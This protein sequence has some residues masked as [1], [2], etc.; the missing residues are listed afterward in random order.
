MVEKSSA[1]VYMERGTGAASA[2]KRDGEGDDT[3]FFFN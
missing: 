2:E 1:A 3:E